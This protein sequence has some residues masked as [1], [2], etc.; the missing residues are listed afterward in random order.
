MRSIPLVVTLAFVALV[1]NGCMGMNSIHG[2][3]NIV[4]ETREV[5]GITGIEVNG[6]G[7]I[8]LKQGDTE[9][10]E[11]VAD[12]NLMEHLSSDVSGSKLTL[13]TRNWVNIN[14]TEKV[15]YKVWVKDLTS[16]GIS[17]SAEVEADGVHTDSLLVAVSGSGD[18]RV[19][20]EAGVQKI[21]I[22][23]SANYEGGD[24][25]SREASLV[26]SGSGKA[27]L[28]VSEKLD[29]QVSGSGDVEYIG[30]PEVTK[31]ISGSG[32]VKPRS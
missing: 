22:S 7:K 14:P 2:S 1:T 6:S 4:S 18:I 23:G 15:L 28:A 12:D 27:V 11:I 19:S 13:G 24:L 5:S 16:L 17:G 29:V 31:S 3:G 26:V 21:S 30:T 8:I 25:K 9:R 32:S 10:L 20:G